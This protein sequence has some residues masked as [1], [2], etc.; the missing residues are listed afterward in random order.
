MRIPPREHPL[1]KVQVIC[2]IPIAHYLDIL[3][4][5]WKRHEFSYTD[6]LSSD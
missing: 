2:V 6:F 5:G 1:E 3:L 4:E